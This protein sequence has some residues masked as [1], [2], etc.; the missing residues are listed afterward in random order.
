LVLVMFS[1]ICSIHAFSCTCTQEKIS[2]QE[3][4]SYEVIVQGEIVSVE[5][6]G[7]LGKKY[8][9]LISKVLKGEIT[10]DTIIVTTP[11]ESLCGISAVLGESWILLGER[12]ITEG[13]ETNNCNWSMNLND[14]D[15]REKNILRKIKRNT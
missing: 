1:L 10:T 8:K 4:E 7:S 9:V 12:L 14:L 13:F 6:S 2:K 3:I 5:D 11:P 15:K